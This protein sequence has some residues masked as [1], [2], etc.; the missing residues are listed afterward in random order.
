MMA[1]LPPGV[2]AIDAASA[3]DNL[4]DAFRCVAE[5]LEEE[6][7]APVLIVAGGGNLPSISLY[8]AALARAGP[9]RSIIS[10]AI[11]QGWRSPS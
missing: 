11:L 8:A 1:L 6:T 3:G 2:S 9:S 4:T 10:T 5:G 7:G